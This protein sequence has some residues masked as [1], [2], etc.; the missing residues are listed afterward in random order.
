M[1]LGTISSGIWLAHSRNLNPCGFFFWGCLKDKV[2]NSKPQMEELK[3]NIH[4]K[5]ANMPA[6]QL[7]RVNQNFICWSKECLRVEGRHFQHL[8]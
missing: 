1:S 2:Y 6:E 3:A 5:I 7:Q 4:R 8:L